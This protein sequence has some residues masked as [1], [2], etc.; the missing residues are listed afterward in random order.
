VLARAYLDQLNRSNGIAQDRSAAIAAALH[1]AEQLKGTERQT[2]LTTLAT[3]LDGDAAN[4]G[5]A[6]K[7][8]LLSAAV[9]DLAK[10]QS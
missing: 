9:K 3:Q 7:V 2:A 5:D 6:A 10:A 1:H 8:R 4:A